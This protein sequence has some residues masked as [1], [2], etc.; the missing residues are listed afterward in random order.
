MKFID[1]FSSMK[2]IDE[3]QGSIMRSTESKPCSICGE[4]TEYIE[5]NY[6]GYFCSE[7][8]VKKMDDIYWKAMEM[9]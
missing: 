9:M 2:K 3:V 8:C 6:E 1:K 5:I 7:E 4:M